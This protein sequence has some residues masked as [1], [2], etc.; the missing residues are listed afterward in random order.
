MATERIEYNELLPLGSRIQSSNIEKATADTDY[1][2]KK[3]QE[4]HNFIEELKRQ[5]VPYDV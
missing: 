1:Q 2:K 3:E 4:Y 5:T